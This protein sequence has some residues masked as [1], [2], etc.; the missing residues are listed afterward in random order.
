MISRSIKSPQRQMRM[1]HFRVDGT[2]TASLL[3]GGLDATLTDNGVGDWTITFNEKFSRI[4]VVV[5]LSKTSATMIRCVPALGSVQVLG[6]QMD[7]TTAS[8]LDCDI[9]VLGADVADQI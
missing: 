4:P 3:E 8:D 9:M 1:L 2:G 5:G 7:G 6:F